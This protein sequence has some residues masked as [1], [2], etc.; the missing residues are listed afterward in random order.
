MSDSESIHV[1][2]DPEI[3]P[4]PPT[5]PA[6]PRAMVAALEPFFDRVVERVVDAISKRIELVELGID[7]L[8][9]RIDVRFAELERK[10]AARHKLVVNRIGKLERELRTIDAR[11]TA[12]ETTRIVL[13]GLG[14]TQK[15]RPRGRKAKR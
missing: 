9:Q 5:D 10:G 8:E 11:V 6:S 3:P 4:P 1:D 14:A 15:R 13:R 7:T 12:L 2:V